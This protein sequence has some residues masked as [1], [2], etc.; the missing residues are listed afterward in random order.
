M[1]IRG[2]NILTAVVLADALTATDD[3]LDRVEAIIAQYF[4]GG[5]ATG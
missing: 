4:H 3:D 2:L 5:Q 1:K